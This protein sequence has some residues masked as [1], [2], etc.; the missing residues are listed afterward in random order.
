[1]FKQGG[2][3]KGNRRTE[4]KTSIFYSSVLESSVLEWNRKRKKLSNVVPAGLYY[5]GG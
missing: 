3:E 1:M 4:T 5:V 2:G